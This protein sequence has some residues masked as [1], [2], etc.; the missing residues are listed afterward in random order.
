MVISLYEVLG[1]SPTAGAAE[2]RAAYLHRARQLHPDQSGDTAGMQELNAAWE[3]L[4]DP[5]RRAAYDTEQ[6][7]APLPPARRPSP[8]EPWEDV[9]ARVQAD[10]AR[11]MSEPFD[12]VAAFLRALPVLAVL[13]LLFVVFVFTAYAGGR[14]TDD[15]GREAPTTQP[16][17][18]EVGG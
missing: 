14:A 17:Q 9:D 11:R 1:A 7:P 18:A 8:A 16:G 5:E 3:T 10:I 13:F 15:T 12:P 4:G 6:A 2:L